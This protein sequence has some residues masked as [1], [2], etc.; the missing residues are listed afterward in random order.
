MKRYRKLIAL[1]LMLGCISL[2]GCS[3]AAQRMLQ[4]E[5]ERLQ[6]SVDELH[7]T[8]QRAH[9]AK[10]WVMMSGVI[11]EQEFSLPEEEFAE[12]R[13]ILLLTEPAPP[14]LPEPA[15][16][17]MSPERRAAFYI[18]L[19][20]MD[21]N[22][23]ALMRI[24]INDNPWTRASEVQGK[25]DECSSSGGGRAPEWCLPDDEWE[26]FSALPTIREARDWA[27]RE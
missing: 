17:G 1:L 26:K 15:A 18:E 12:L 16:A 6:H 2:S 11:K 27:E 13:R 19:I 21:E 24:A 5:Q 10:V 3:S 9:G 4:E 8:L 14:Q 20:F 22:A 25:A 7:A 23:E